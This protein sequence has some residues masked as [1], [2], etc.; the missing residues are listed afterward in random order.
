M[1]DIDL[2]K[3]SVS[4]L[5]QREAWLREMLEIQRLRLAKEYNDVVKPAKTSTAPV[6]KKP[7]KSTKIDSKK[8]GV[9]ENGGQ[10]I[11]NRLL[12]QRT[13]NSRINTST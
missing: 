6:T 5:S 4:E 7:T 2:S 9:D 10:L 1:T 12:Q 3:L 8:S 13:R 11:T